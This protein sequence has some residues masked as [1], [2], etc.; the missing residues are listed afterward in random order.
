MIKPILTANAEYS[1]SSSSMSIRHIN[2]ADFSIGDELAS[3]EIF[4]QIP[5][6]FECV[7]T[8]LGYCNLEIVVH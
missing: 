8:P 4:L 5:E 7:N 1:C 6:S 3:L 2:S